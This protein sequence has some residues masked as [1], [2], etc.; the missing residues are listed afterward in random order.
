MAMISGA[1]GGLLDVAFNFN[2]QAFLD[3]NLLDQFFR[4]GRKM[5]LFGDETWLKLFPKL[6]TR[7][8]GVSSFFV[9]DTV[10]VD[11]NISRHLPEELYRD[12]WHLMPDVTA[13]GVDILAATS[14]SLEKKRKSIC[15]DV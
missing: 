4:I 15:A 14:N 9:K 13:P 10:E 3:D 2:T 6:F 7:Q 1:I 11:L 12:D 5:T 8:D